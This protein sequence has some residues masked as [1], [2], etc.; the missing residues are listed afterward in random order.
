LWGTDNSAHYGLGIQGALMQLYS[1]TIGSDIAMGYGSSTNFTEN[2]RIKGSG[3]VEIGTASNPAQPSSANAILDVSSTNKGIFIPRVTT[4]QRKAI[5]VTADD[6]GLLVFDK[7]RDLLYMFDGIKWVPFATATNETVTY[8]TGVYDPQVSGGSHFGYTVAVDSIYAVVGSPRDS[9]GNN[10]SQGT[11]HVYKKQ[12]GNWIAVAELTASDG[13]AYMEF[14][15]RVAISGDY[16]VAGVPDYDHTGSL[17]NCGAAYIFHRV[18][19]NWTQTQ[20]IM[21]PA[22]FQSEGFATSVAM[23]NSRLVIGVPGN[24]LVG[25][26]GAIFVYVLNG[27]TWQFDTT[28]TASGGETTNRL[29]WSISI[30]KT[31]NYIVAGAPYSNNTQLGFTASGAV[32]VFASDN[33]GNWAQQSKLTQKYGANSNQH[34]GNSVSIYNDQTLVSTAKGYCEMFGKFFNS[35]LYTS[36]FSS[37]A[38]GGVNGDGDFG[39]NLIL[40]QNYMFI[41]APG[42]QAQGLAGAGTVYVYKK[43]NNGQFIFFKRLTDKEP[44]TGDQFGFGL[45]FDGYNLLIGSP[46]ENSQTAKGKVLFCIVSD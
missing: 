8:S 32:Y 42:D 6:L 19:N 4:A 2:V 11:I 46:N 5:A 9:V 20:K 18:G 41:S 26:T 16:I 28:L 10:A 37:P 34:F 23:T 44:Y 38:T 36:N 31:G 12:N 15:S 43:N 40:H 22:P 27:N 24:Y 14:G 39:D 29:G 25:R 45:A 1:P 30:N 17:F 3:K 7:D 33:N 21:D 13:K 35:W